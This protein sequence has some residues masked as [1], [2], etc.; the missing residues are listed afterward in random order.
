MK[1]EFRV[2]QALSGLYGAGIVEQLLIAAARSCNYRVL[3]RKHW[4][5]I[6]SRRQYFE[7]MRSCVLRKPTRPANLRY[8]VVAHCR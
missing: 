1:S 7:D 6:S 4:V 3:E 5:L 2:Y 8:L